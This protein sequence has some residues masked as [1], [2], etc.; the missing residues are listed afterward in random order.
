LCRLTILR[1]FSLGGQNCPERVCG[2][3]GSSIGLYLS[4]GRFLQLKDQLPGAFR[5]LLALDISRASGACRLVELHRKVLLERN[6]IGADDIVGFFA[7]TEEVFLIVSLIVV[8]AVRN[9][10][11]E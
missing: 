7:L 9:L 11:F 3:L 4:I 6:G 1:C 5:R 2:S 10:D 8:A